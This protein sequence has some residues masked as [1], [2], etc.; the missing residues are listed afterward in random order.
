MNLRALLL[1]CVLLASSTLSPSAL[2]QSWS[3]LLLQLRAEHRGE[4]SGVSASAPQMRQ[5]VYSDAA[6]EESSPAAS[7]PT[8]AELTRLLLGIYID[9]VERTALMA[10]YD[11]EQYLLPLMTILNEIGATLA[12]EAD[13]AEGHMLVNTPGGRAE[14][15]ATG[16]RVVDGQILVTESGLREQL[17]VDTRFSQSDYA[18][19]LILPW[20][21]ETPRDVF[22]GIDMPEPDFA[23]PSL[24]LRS[25]RGDLYI[26]DSSDGLDTTSDYYL[27]GSLKGG[28]WQ[29]R[30]NEDGQGNLRGA[31]YFLSKDFDRSLLLLG[32]ADYSLH[33]LL[34]TVEQTGVQWLYSSRALSATSEVDISRAR[35][36]KRLNN[37][38]RTI[39]G[40]TDPGAVAEL[41][42]DGNVR[43]RVRARLDGSFEFPDVELPTRG[44]AQVEVLVRDFRTGAL[45]EIQDFSRRSGV[46][47]LGDGQHSVFT[48][49]G[50]EGNPLDAQ[51]PSDGLSAAL[52][53]R[54]GLSEDVTL[55]LGHQRVGQEQDSAAALSM[56]LSKRWFGSLGMAQNADRSALSLA[57]E[58][59]GENWSLDV[60]MRE[61]RFQ[62]QREEQVAQP[63]DSFILAQRQWNR[64]FNLHYG[65]TDDISLGLIGRDSLGVN[66]EHSFVLPSASWTN[67]R[68]LSVNLRPNY[69]GVYRL[70]SRFTP[71]R[72]TTL[73]YT[74]ENSRHALDIRYLGSFGQEYYS[75]VSVD[76]N[77]ELRTELGMAAEFE[78]Q[79]FGRVQVGLVGGDQDIGYALDWE[80]Q[81][82]PGV[83]SRLRIS[84]TESFAA[85]DDYANDSDFGYE[86]GTGDHFSF[87]WQLTFDFA[88][89]Q[90]RIV[91]ADSK[92]RTLD[93]ATLTGDL[94]VDGK[95]LG[96]EHGVDRVELLVDGDN[97]TASVKGGRYYLDGLSPGMHKVSLD[98]RHL[99]LELSPVAGQNY[100]VRLEKSAVTEV[101]IALEVKYSAAGRIRDQYGENLQNAVLLVTDEHG[102][103]LETL[104]SDQFG[105]YRTGNL[106]PGR[107]NLLVKLRGEEVGTRELLIENDYLFDQDVDTEVSL[108]MDS[109]AIS[110]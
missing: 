26:S 79:R 57:L 49:L 90:R 96:P 107:Y 37:G 48:A 70:D 33:P 10:L 24:S 74:I 60:G 58:G 95:K 68:N 45:V 105:L 61:S 8:E 56:A 91:A 53:W 76:E 75:N 38:V 34:P 104:R 11:G 63:E 82:A 92:M 27:S 98:S 22:A 85:Y 3:E 4:D 67:R 47:L 108:I 2:A 42:V 12:E 59:G 5:I 106:A 78:N 13:V 30:V 16:L 73:R 39:S 62:T 1:I 43:S 81:L 14:L 44:Y 87:T 17:L 25:L 20:S 40:I 31:D 88:V 86:F 29:A 54:Y 35:S 100:W 19:F 9:G 83:N 102:T 110:L 21:L 46:E 72:N 103:T 101:P 51:F 66:G 64:Y 50:Q 23:P 71:T 80:A 18:I 77:N 97:Y 41:R 6:D 28:A 89:T 36:V 55:E 15:T 109:P 93:S 94:I 7:S 52:Q 84:Q 65:L 69:E 99:P 32:N